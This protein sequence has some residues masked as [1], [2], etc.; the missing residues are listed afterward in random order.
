MGEHEL[1]KLI[2]SKEQAIKGDVLTTEKLR[3][4]QGEIE[5]F[6]DEKLK[7][8]ENSVLYLHYRK[9]KAPGGKPRSLLSSERGYPIDGEAWIKPWIDFFDQYLGEKTIKRRLET[10]EYWI[11]SRIRGEDETILI[12]RRDGHGEKAHVIIDG[13]N[14]TIRIEDNQKAPEELVRHIATILTLPDGK[15]VRTTREGVG[16]FEEENEEQIRSA[17]KISVHRTMFREYSVLEV[18]NSG[19]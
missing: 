8:D 6:L 9:F 19:K 15:K 13:K 14:A 4:L 12:G 3:Q 1:Y 16:F 17:V 10:D 2:K 18:Y 5:S 7:E 11:E